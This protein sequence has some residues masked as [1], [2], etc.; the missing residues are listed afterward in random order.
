ML[1]YPAV[2]LLNGSCVRLYRGSFD[3]VSEFSHDPLAVAERFVADGAR[4]LHVV[5]LNG[6]RDG[7]PGHLNTILRIRERC[8]VHMQVG[9]GVRNRRHLDRYLEA[10]VDRVI[11][12]TAVATGEDWVR[13]ALQE[14]G[15]ERVA[16]ALDERE[17]RILVAGWRHDSPQQRHSVARFLRAGGITHV[18]YTDATRDGTLC[19]PDIRRCESVIGY[20]FRTI[21]AGGIATLEDIASLGAVGA[22]GVVVGSAIYRGRIGVREATDCAASV[23]KSRAEHDGGWRRGASAGKTNHSLS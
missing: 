5:D 18:V 21:V 10:G 1:M 20:G 16:A 3:D 19:S 23:T 22:A 9:G 17:Q 15:P 2:D 6:A 14:Y 13:P 4:A 12:G 8:S 11:L 7:L